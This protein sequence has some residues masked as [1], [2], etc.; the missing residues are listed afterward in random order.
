[1]T[2]GISLGAFHAANFALKRADL[3]PLALCMSGNYDP[4]TWNG[5]GERG[6]QTYFNNPLDYVGQLDGDHL[7]WLRSRL[8]PAAGLRS[9]PVG[10]HHGLAGV[11]QAARRH[12]RREEHPPRARPVGL[13]RPARLVVLARPDRPPSPEVLLM[14]TDHLIGLL[15]G[16][17][18]DW[19]H[20][21]ETLLGR[22]GPVQHDGATHN[23][24]SERITIEPFDLRAKPRYD[25]VV[26]RLAWWYFVPREWL[27]KVALMDDVYLLNSPFTFQAMEKHAAYCAML[28]LG[29]KVPKTVLVPHK[30]PPDNARFQYTAEKYNLPFDLGEIAATH[31]LPAV[32]EALRRRP[33]GRRHAHQGRGAAAQGLRRVRR[34]ADAPAGVD[35]GL[36]Q[37]RALVVDRRRDDGHGLPARRA[38]AQPLRRLAR[39]PL[40]RDRRRGADDLAADQR[41]L[42]LGVQLLRDARARHRGAPDR[43]RQRL[44]GRRADVAALLLA[45]GDQR[46]AEVVDLLHRHRPPLA[47]RG[48]R[49]AHVLRG[50]RPRRTCPTRRSWPSTAGWPTTTSRSSATRSSAR[51]RW[52]TSTS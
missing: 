9:G 5:W 12:A 33:V 15:L 41:L 28:R 50:R 23:V 29:L 14:S 26:D 25:L 47:Q 7:D 35:R 46:A 42:P 38:D 43:L 45:V 31:R 16:T 2:A 49:H 22:V 20:A 30:N 34:A 37:V 24:T 4:S 11:H 27:K 18:E 48:P 13:R 6:E 1:M 21:F 44:A 51:P 36:R 32:H 40:A 8:T 39:L 19:P 10:G 17:E 3:F 52:R